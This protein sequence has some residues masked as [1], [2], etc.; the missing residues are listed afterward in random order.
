M[1]TAGLELGLRTSGA[2]E[3]YER[4][5]AVYTK[6]IPRPQ[7]QLEQLSTKKEAKSL[8]ETEMARKRGAVADGGTGVAA[9]EGRDRN[10]AV[11]GGRRPEA[12][13]GRKTPGLST[14]LPAGRNSVWFRRQPDGLPNAL[15]LGMAGVERKIV[16]ARP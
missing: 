11:R 1:P 5:R 6:R 2:A 8:K 14:G 9:G 16:R 10:S 7:A 13:E 4:R 3:R 15:I 12:I